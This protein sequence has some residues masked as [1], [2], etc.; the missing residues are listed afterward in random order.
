MLLL[1]VWH[2]R[3]SAVVSADSIKVSLFYC[4]SNSEL[5]CYFSKS[6]INCSLLCLRVLITIFKF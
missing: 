2:I 3:S 5:H 6:R 4:I 1:L